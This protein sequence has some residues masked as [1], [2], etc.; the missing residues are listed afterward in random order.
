M[1]VVKQVATL[2]QLGLKFVFANV[3]E[4]GLEMVPYELS[5]R[6][7]LYIRVN[8]DLKM[9]LVPPRKTNMFNGTLPF[10]Q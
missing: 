3:V 2:A 9:A 8:A 5:L 1:E 10:F 6:T 7:E 4:A